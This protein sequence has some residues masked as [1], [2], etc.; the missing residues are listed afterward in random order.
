MLKGNETSFKI[1]AFLQD[2]TLDR[3]R[4]RIREKDKEITN[5]R[6]ERAHY[7]Q[8]ASSEGQ[9]VVAN[10]KKGIQRLTSVKQAVEEG[11]QAE[12]TRR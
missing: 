10:L 7:D 12:K 8:E 5:L 9:D 3:Q 2:R 4:Q 6:M 11:L 1:S